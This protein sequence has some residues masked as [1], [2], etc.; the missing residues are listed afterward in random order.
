MLNQAQRLDLG[1]RALADP[2]RRA[3]V[4]RLARGEASVSEL[5]GPFDMSLP[6]VHQHLRVLEDAGLLVCRKEGRV[7]RCRLDARALGRVAEWIERHRSLWERRLDA[8]D[9]HLDDKR[10]IR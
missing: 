7:R 4:E 3:I 9:R 2:T 8:L 5:A 1:F 10:R 6:A